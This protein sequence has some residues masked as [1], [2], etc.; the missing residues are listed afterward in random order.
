MI[1]A[2]APGWG[3]FDQ[4][5][6]P[7]SVDNPAIPNWMSGDGTDIGALEVNHILK[8]TGVA[9]AGSEVHVMFATTSDKT[10]RLLYRGDA[11]GAAMTPLPGVVIGTGGIVTVTNGDV[12]L[13]P[14]RFYRALHE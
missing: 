1:D 2:G 9:V 10:Y 3:P 13:L 5:G 8:M 12:G 6:Q 14:S 7:R 11:E 4:R